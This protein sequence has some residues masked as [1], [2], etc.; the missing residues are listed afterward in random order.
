MGSRSSGSSE[1]ERLL[2]RLELAQVLLGP[3]QVVADEDAELLDL[4][5]VA[6]EPRHV[7]GG[8]LAGLGR[9][10]AEPAVDL[11]PDPPL[12]LGRSRR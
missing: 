9:E 10:V 8:V 7:L 12:Q 11:H 2:Q 1:A 6:H 3:G 4:V 5:V